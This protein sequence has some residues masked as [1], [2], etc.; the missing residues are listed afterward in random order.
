MHRFRVYEACTN[1]LEIALVDEA[2]RCHVA[3]TAGLTPPIGTELDGPLG[4]R[5]LERFKCMNTGQLFRVAFVARDC[6][7]Q[8]TIERLHPDITR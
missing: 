6:D 2:G 5:E 3:R 7:R 1:G 4:S 8:A